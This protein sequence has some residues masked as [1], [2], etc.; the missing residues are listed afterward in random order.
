MNGKTNSTGYKLGELTA[1]M[2][3]MNNSITSLTSKFDNFMNQCQQNRTG[4]PPVVQLPQIE[5]RLTD[6]ETS[7]ESTAKA[8]VAKNLSRASYF[9][10]AAT[11]GSIAS[12]IILATWYGYQLYIAIHH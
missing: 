12:G 2:K 10:L 11:S 3:A 4:C 7:L 8:T 6:V 9:K 1:E 5:K